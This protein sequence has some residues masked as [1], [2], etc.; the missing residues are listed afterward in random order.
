[1]EHGEIAY[2]ENSA[3]MFTALTIKERTGAKQRLLLTC[4]PASYHSG[5]CK[6]LP[7]KV[8]CFKL[9]TAVQH[10]ASN[11][12]NGKQRMPLSCNDPV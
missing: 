10:L 6:H 8:D 7:G 2:C 3:L 9:T 11:H 5:K 12:D 4:H 1:M